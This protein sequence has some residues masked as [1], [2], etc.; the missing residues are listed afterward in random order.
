MGS[1]LGASGRLAVIL[2]NDRGRAAPLTSQQQI[3]G[4]WVVWHNAA[5]R[6][7]AEFAMAGAATAPTNRPL[8]Q[9]TERERQPCKCL[10]GTQPRAVVPI[11]KLRCVG[12][13]AQAAP[14][15]PEFQRLR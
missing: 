3:R 15:L 5:P 14:R 6:K 4:R 10:R 7:T 11:Q 12:I 9:G 1:T 13:F 8:C 2:A